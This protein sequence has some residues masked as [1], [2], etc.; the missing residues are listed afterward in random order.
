VEDVYRRRL[1]R[2]NSSLG[3][4]VES[5]ELNYYMKRFDLKS[6]G[7]GMLIGTVAVA[8]IGAA[9]DTAA[10][11]SEYRVVY[12]SVFDGNFQ[13]NL[14]KAAA[15]GWKLEESDTFTDRHAYAVMSRIKR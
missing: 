10:V 12:G 4:D 7:L 1:G 14:S 5:S 8:G 13:S 9:S 6:L 2:V 11:G 3:S 15:D